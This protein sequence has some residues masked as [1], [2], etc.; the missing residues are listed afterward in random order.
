M[1]YLMQNS[2]RPSRRI[3]SSPFIKGLKWW[4][5]EAIMV[6]VPK[7]LIFK[8]RTYQP[9]CSDEDQYMGA[10]I[11]TNPPVWRDDFI[12]AIQSCGVTNFDTYPVEIINPENSENLKE[13]RDNGINIFDDSYLD[14]GGKFTNYKAVNILGLIAAADMKKSITTTHGHIP[15]IDVDFDELVIDDKKTKDIKMFRLAESSNAILVHESLRD[16]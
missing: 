12:E 15:L 3:E 10:F 7:P 4:S 5:G 2:D 14:K 1:Y 9:A 16:M 11:Y 13:L 6:D 8:L